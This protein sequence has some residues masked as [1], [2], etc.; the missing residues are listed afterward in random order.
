MMFHRTRIKYN[1]HD[2]TIN[3]KNVAHTKNTKFLGVIIDNKLTWSDHIIYIKNKI[4][5][6]IGILH[7]TH[8]FL[9]KN[10]LRNL[11]YTFVYPHLIYCIEVWENTNDIHLDPLIKIQKKSVSVITF[12]HYLDSTAPI[13][14]NVNILNFKKLVTQ[15]IALLMFKYNTGSLPVPISNLFS[16]NRHHYYTRQINDLQLNTG[17]GENVYKL[18]SFHGVR[19]WNH[20]S[21]KIQTDVS[22]ACFKNLSK[23]YLRNNDIPQRIR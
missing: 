9:T 10:T 21:K 19:I 5:K 14:H 2:I 16:I 11:Y 23:T 18:F 7:K 20:I 3:G 8:D 13:F 1:H 22:Y 12:S 6:S 4:Y 15:R 17:R